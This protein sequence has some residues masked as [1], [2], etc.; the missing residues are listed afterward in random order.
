MIYT[1]EDLRRKDR[2]MDEANAKELLK[3]GE[4]GFFAMQAENRGA[5]GIPM[6][7]AW[8]GS[9]S[10]YFHCAFE[11]RKI[12][13]LELCNSV[14]FSVVGQTKVISGKFT[15]EFESVILECKAYKNLSAEEKMKALELLVEKYSPKDKIKG[16]KYAANSLKETEIIR[17]DIEK[18]SGKRKKNK[19]TN[20]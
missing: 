20:K 15:T 3:N 10:I 17:L 13:L 19:S 2:F 8:N 9:E 7:Y 4:Y 18:W 1:D 5:Y 11:G 16:M 6:S 12:R 14:S